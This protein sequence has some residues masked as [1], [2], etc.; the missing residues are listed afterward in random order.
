MDI[1]TLNSNSDAS[2]G[3]TEM[4]AVVPKKEPLVSAAS[5]ATKPP[6]FRKMFRDS[7][8]NDRIEARQYLIQ[9]LAIPNIKMGIHDILCGILDYWLGGSRYYGSAPI[10]QRVGGMIVRSMTGNTD[11]SRQYRGKPVP[12]PVVQNPNDQT[13]SYS[14][15]D[16]VIVPDPNTGET[17]RDARLKAEHILMKLQ[18][19]CA[20]YGKARVADL[21]EYVGRSP[22]FT[23][24]DRGWYDLSQSYTTAVTGGYLLVFPRAVQFDQEE[25]R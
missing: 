1:V 11:Y 4:P 15:D 18:Q 6:T 8:P 16:I 14:Y 21:F 23:D 13:V 17:M 22:R 12:Q 7:F 25:G 5:V 2:R 24:N 3:K 19:D 9:D 10:A 20:T